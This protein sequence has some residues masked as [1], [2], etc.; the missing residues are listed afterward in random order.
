MYASGLSMGLEKDVTSLK[1]LYEIEITKESEI[2]CNSC[3]PTT[4]EKTK[5]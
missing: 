5:F 3:L 4:E 1:S 2:Y